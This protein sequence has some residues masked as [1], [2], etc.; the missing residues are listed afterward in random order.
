MEDEARY[1]ISLSISRENARKFLARLATEP[2]FRDWVEANPVDAL[3][4]EGIFISRE[5][6][7]ETVKLPPQKEIAHILYAGDS[8]WGETASPFGWLIV[9]VFGAMPVTAPRSPSGD[10]AG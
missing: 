7:P 3:G 9:F 8:M 4:E 1:E 6:L 2:D 5:L 10:G